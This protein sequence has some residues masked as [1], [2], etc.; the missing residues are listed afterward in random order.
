MEADVHCFYDASGRGIPASA[1][2]CK[3]FLGL[4]LPLARVHT[5]REE[6]Y[7]EY[8]F[9][10]SSRDVLIGCKKLHQRLPDKGQ[11][12]QSGRQHHSADGMRHESRAEDEIA[13]EEAI[14]FV[15]ELFRM[16]VPP[17]TFVTPV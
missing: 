5:H 12:A 13:D 8:G 17:V 1:C 16:S 6:P 11:P 10:D 3:L 7:R 2:G 14:L 4:Q 15:P 9:S